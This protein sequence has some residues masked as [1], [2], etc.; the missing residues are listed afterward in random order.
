MELKALS[1]NPSPETSIT[2]GVTFTGPL[3]DCYKANL[4]LRTASRILMRI[5]TFKASN[6][7]RLKKHLIDFPWEL[8]L[9][10][11]SQP[12]FQI[13]THRSRLRHSGAITDR[14]Q[15]S[16]T[17]RWRKI[18]IG[19]ETDRDAVQ[20]QKL[21]VRAKNDIFTVSL[22]SSGDNL[23]RRGIKQDVTAAPLRETIAA[24]LLI[25]A[26]YKPPEPL[27]DPMCG[28]GTFS[29]EA[30][31]QI[32]KIPAGW[33]RNFAFYRWPVFK[34]TSKRWNHIRKRMKKEISEKTS[35]NIFAT[36]IDPVA[37][38]ILGRN[39]EAAGFSR[40]I[41]IA[42][43]DFF[44]LSPDNWNRPPGL[45][46]INAPFGR[47]IGSLDQSDRLFEKL[48]AH[49]KTRWHGW[50]VGLVIPRRNLLK[51]VPFS[52]VPLSIRYGGLRLFLVTG[53]IST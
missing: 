20:N 28:A 7:P 8:Y 39:S 49:L 38:E 4:C 24:A 13:T 31:M 18:G 45:I 27:I 36:D 14:F 29:L 30:A 51:K 46:T 26:E 32:H 2:G 3:Q 1:L 37:C 12:Q 50:K 42:T 25:L 48:F 6:F 43:H 10:A 44:E 21:F 53:R 33:F 16:I 22:D 34:I 19:I 40:T 23:Y 47:R 17:R 11:G 9:Q 15:D 35:A 5:H 41:Q 52:T